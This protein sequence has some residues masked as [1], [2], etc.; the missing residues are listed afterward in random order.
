MSVRRL[1]PLALAVALLAGCSAV[2]PENY[3][4]I[5]AGMTRDE[6]YQILGKPS[7][8]S[9][10]GIGP[11]TVSNETWTGGKHSIRIT[12]G[13]DKVALKSIDAAGSEKR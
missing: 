6:V 1:V 2:T 3:A 10:G 4:R 11:L 8:V 9:G 5:Q 13:G 12:F 7:E